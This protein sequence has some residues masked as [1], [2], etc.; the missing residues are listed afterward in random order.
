MIAA[1]A[2]WLLAPV[3][4]P[5]DPS[6]YTPP[7]PLPAGL[8]PIRFEEYKGKRT[9]CASGPQC[10]AAPEVFAGWY[11]KIGPSQSYVRVEVHALPP[12]AARSDGA[13]AR[14]V[15]LMTQDLLLRPHHWFQHRGGTLRVWRTA[16][17]RI[18][19]SEIRYG[20]PETD[21][22]WKLARHEERDGW[23]LYIMIRYND[24]VPDEA[25]RALLRTAF[26]DGP[27]GAAPPAA[28]RFP[29]GP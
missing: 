17:G 27:L 6:F 29:V 11:G 19:Q 10:W 18:A 8:E 7:S 26:V 25:T 13:W 21:R 5:F 2:L 15:R 12:A 16:R 28:R 23:T 14:K 3:V 1:A 22:H 4:A 24:S 20:G 9:L